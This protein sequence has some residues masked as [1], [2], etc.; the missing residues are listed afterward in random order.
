MQ[1]KATNLGIIGICETL[2]KAD[3]AETKQ[4][5]LTLNSKLD[6]VIN[7]LTGNRHKPVCEL[8]KLKNWSE[9]NC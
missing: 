5:F 1:L 9:T 7:L 3:S 2:P 6:Y 8:A 4:M